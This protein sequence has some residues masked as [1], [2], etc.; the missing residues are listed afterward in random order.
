MLKPE[1]TAHAQIILRQNYKTGEPIKTLTPLQGG[2][3]SAAYKFSDGGCGYVLRLSHTQDNF[4]RDRIASRWSSPDLPIPQIIAIGKHQNQY[5]AISPFFHGE[6]FEKLSASSLEQA[7]PHFLS[8]M[9]ALQSAGL[10]AMQG[11]GTLTTQGK[12]AFHSW[13]EAL[14]DVSNDHPDSL[15]HGWKKALAGMPTAERKYIRFYKQLTKLAPYCPQQKCLI[16]ADLLY[17]NLLVNGQK[18]S[19]VLDW[20]CAMIGDPAYDIAIFSF[21]EPWYPAFAQTRLVFRMKQ[22][23]LAQ[24]PGNIVHFEQ[25]MAAYQIHLAL[26]NIAY[27]LYSDGKHDCNEHIDRLE[28][29]LRSPN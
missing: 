22:A 2:E 24:S 5:Y 10:D 18:I 15:I 23:Y 6:P 21:F 20:G 17:Q 19:A 29:V 11:Y 26:G 27:C 8:M 25:R 28:E 9:A 12:G 7:I 14:L 3:W 16:H 13:H 1:F 4:Y